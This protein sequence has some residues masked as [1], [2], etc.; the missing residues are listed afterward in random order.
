MADCARLKVENGAVNRT[1]RD[2]FAGLLEKGAAGA[3]FAPVRQPDGDM[4]MSTLIKEPGQLEYLDP[5]APVTP[6]SAARL[7][8]TLTYRDPGCTIA[9]F[10][11]PCDYRAYLELVKLRQAT[12]EPVLAVVPD[13]LGRMETRDFLALAGEH[14]E[15][16]GLEFHRRAAR[17]DD[18]LPMLE[19]CRVCEFPTHPGADLGLQLL[20]LDIE[21]EIFLCA[22]TEK[23][24]S[25]MEALDLENVA[26]PKARSESLDSLIKER[27]AS[28]DAM[29]KEYEEKV[30]SFSALRRTLRTCINCYNCR[31]A[32]PVCYCRECVFLTDTFRHDPEQYMRWAERRGHVKLPTDTIFFHLTRMLHISTLCVGCGQCSTACP[33]DLPVMELF[34]SAASRTQKRFNYEPGRSV[35]DPL[36]TA[37]F[38]DQEFLELGA[39]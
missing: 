9:A 12:I 4:V 15:N 27:T 35:E 37:V 3:V 1:L 18:T 13:C 11:R 33:M 30:D 20:G 2:L 10:L 7:L 6:T 5:L 23:G 39:D 29:L 36:P 34:R 22:G 26:S 25:A 28:R 17:G 14:G 21:D 16:T 31:V 8:A 24:R 32:C 19:A 38:E